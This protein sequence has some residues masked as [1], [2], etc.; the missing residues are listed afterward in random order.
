MKFW[1]EAQI[2]TDEHAVALFRKGAVCRQSVFI[3]SF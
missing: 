1:N 2:G 3:N